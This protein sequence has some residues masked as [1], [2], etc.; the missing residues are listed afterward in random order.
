M[1]MTDQTNVCRGKLSGTDALA[2]AQSA[3]LSFGPVRLTTGHPVWRSSCPVIATSWHEVRLS[4]RPMVTP[5]WVPGSL[6]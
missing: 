6:M 5:F 3:R 2:T 1:R 4:D